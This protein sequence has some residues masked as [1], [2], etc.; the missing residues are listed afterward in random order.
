M[1]DQDHIDERLARLT[2]AT[3]NVRPRPDFT[4]RVMSAATA[5][6]PPKV[7]LDGFWAQLPRAARFFIPA[8]ALAAVGAIGVAVQNQTDVDDAMA[9]TYDEAE[10][11]W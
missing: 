3:E 7:E 4:A 1:S 6:A 10:L 5:S 8:A 11:E 2:K 9:A